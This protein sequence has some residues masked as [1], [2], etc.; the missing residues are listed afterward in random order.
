MKEINTNGC[1]SVSSNNG[2][3]ADFGLEVVRAVIVLALFI[4]VGCF[5]YFAGRCG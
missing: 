1:C 4:G 5:A 2:A 3:W